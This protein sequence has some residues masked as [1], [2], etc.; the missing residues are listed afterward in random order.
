M[1]NNEVILTIAQAILAN[2]K[3]I[4]SLVDHL[5]AEVREKVASVVA[6]VAAVAVKVESPKPAPIPVAPVMVTPAPVVI[7][8]P[9]PVAVSPS[10]APVMP[11]PPVFTAP[12]VAPVVPGTAPFSDPKGLIDFVMTSYKALGAAKGAGIQGVLSGLGYQN[13]N[14]V[15]PAHYGALFIGIEA[16]K[17]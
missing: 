7:A 11:A 12:V 9:A 14:D 4:Q 13:I 17:A 15:N 6:P 2:T 1:F 3:V 16:L 5:P 8:A 10:S